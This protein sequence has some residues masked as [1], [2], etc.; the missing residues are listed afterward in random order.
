MA[1]WGRRRGIRRGRRGG[2]PRKVVWRRGGSERGVSPWRR[3]EVVGRR[4]AVAAAVGE[5]VGA[6]GCGGHCHC[7][8]LREERAWLRGSLGR[9]HPA[10]IHLGWAV[11]SALEARAAALGRRGVDGVLGRRAAGRQCTAVVLPVRLRWFPGAR[12]PAAVALQGGAVCRSRRLWT[13]WSWRKRCHGGSEGRVVGAGSCSRGQGGCAEGGPHRSSYGAGPRGDGFG[14]E[15][16]ACRLSEV[17]HRLYLC[18]LFL[19]DYL[20][21]GL[22]YVCQFGRSRWIS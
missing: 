8:L 13:R 2:G 6:R 11:S 4:V 7:F 3:G 14:G 20:L 10:Q 1:G 12:R 16:S 22:F 9:R 21:S 18:I 17:I 5:R 19:F 15:S